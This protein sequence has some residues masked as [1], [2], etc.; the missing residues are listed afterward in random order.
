MYQKLDERAQ[1]LSGQPSQT[2]RLEAR[3]YIVS[4]DNVPPERNLSPKQYRSFRM[5]DSAWINSWALTLTVLDA[6]QLIDSQNP[7]PSH[8]S[9]TKINVC[10]LP[11][12]GRDSVKPLPSSRRFYENDTSRLPRILRKL[13]SSTAT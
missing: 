2:E 3:K 5:Y 7:K 6:L 13:T 10:L 11:D 8:I 1:V 4:L 9:F 12:T